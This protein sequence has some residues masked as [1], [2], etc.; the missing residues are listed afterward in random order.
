M[1]TLNDRQEAAVAHK[2]GPMA[3]NACP[4]SGKTT[5]I[6]RRVIRLIERG[7]PADSI[8]TITFTKSAAEDMRTRF[9]EASGGG[10]EYAGARFMTFHAFFFGVLRKAGAASVGSILTDEERRNAVRGMLRSADIPGDD[11]TLEYAITSLSL[12]KNE[13][14]DPEEFQPAEFPAEA[15]RRVYALYEDYKR[16]AGKIDFDDMAPLCRELILS[17]PDILPYWKPRTRYIQID[18]FQDI[19][20]AQYETV[21]LF[22]GHG[23]ILIVGDDDQSIYRFR[24]CRPE[25]LLNFSADFPG[26]AKTTLNVNYRSTARIVELAEAAIAM[27]AGRVAKSM[28]CGRGET[29]AKPGMFRSGDARGEAFLI[30]AM[31][32]RVIKTVPAGEVAVLYRVNSQSRALIDAFMDTRVP[33]TV[34]DDAPIIYEHWTCRDICA[35]IRLAL[36]RT[37]DEAFGRVANRPKRYI[38]KSLIESARRG[39]DGALAE[40]YDMEQTPGYVRQRLEELSFHL[41]AIKGR[42]PAEAVKYIRRTAGYDNYIKDYAEYRRINAKGLFDI[43]AEVESGAAGRETLPDFLEHVGEAVGKAKTDRAERRGAPDRKNPDAVALSTIHQAKG[44][45]YDTVFVIGLAEGLLPYEKS[46][47]EAEIAEERR[48]FYVAVTRAR[49]RLVIAAPT[50]GAE[51]TES[52]FLK[53]IVKLIVSK[54]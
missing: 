16:G 27:N 12:I 42:G 39:K 2:D 32:R 38:R 14:I 11:D 44:L 30:A 33:F 5:V 41:N 23:N 46:R 10:A 7:V 29:G 34:R 6:I 1:E 4:G 9:L 8:L 51:H 24:G 21:R 26:S 25:F 20:R 48:L 22:A 50:E 19:N 54:K 49:N 43:L 31:A 17:R 47:T 28:V 53:P 15:F 45:E 37:D 36:D 13:M 40:L 3:V 18:E 52:R 35:Y